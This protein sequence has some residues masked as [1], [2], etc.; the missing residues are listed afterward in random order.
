MSD[1]SKQ[2][3]VAELLARNG[4]QGATSSGGRRRRGARGISVAELTGDLPVIGEGGS[5]SAHAAPEPEVPEPAGFQ[6][7]PFQ[8][9]P[10]EPG[11]SEQVS[12]SPP[13]PE[14]DYSPISGP[15]TRYDPL[16]P[17]PPAGAE[18]GDPYGSATGYGTAEPT[19]Y[20][21]PAPAEPSYAPAEVETPPPGG[22][23]HSAP[24]PEESGGMP[25][26]P[27]LGA[28]RSGRRRK[29]D[30]DENETMVV[31]PPLREPVEFDPS[32]AAPGGSVSDE[33]AARGGRAARRRAA[34]AE[35]E[36]AGP[37]T[38][39]WSP[40]AGGF[41]PGGYR[42]NGL[43]PEVDG[44]FASNGFG[45]NGSAPGHGGSF[46][47]NG[48]GSDGPVPG[49]GGSFA[50]GGFAPEPDGG[51]APNGFAPEQ[52][53]NYAPGGFAPEQGAGEFGPNGF[54]PEGYAPHGFPPKPGG[55]PPGPDSGNG[56]GPESYG[57]DPRG[58]FAPGY[59]P[60]HGR[61]FGP[62]P[63][64][65]GPFAPDA[66][67]GF[68]PEADAEPGTPHGFA[69]DPEPKPLS[70]MPER[71]KEPPRSRTETLRSRAGGALPAWSARR[72]KPGPPSPEDPD[73]ESGGIP[74]AAW[75]LASQDQQ[76]LSGSTVAGDLLRDGVE[77]SERGRK[78]PPA[79]LDD[80]HTD[81]YDPFTADVDEYDDEDDQDEFEAEPRGKLTSLS[82]GLR[83]K[84]LAAGKRSAERE[85]RPDLDEN[86]RQWMILGGQSAG[87][88]IAGMLLFKGFER[89]WEMLPW[90][91]LPLATI[92]ILGLVALVRVLRRTDDIL[93]TGIAVVVGVFVTLGPLA[94][95]L[96]TG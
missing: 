49:S 75:S 77:R 72:H 41:E 53:G 24:G 86:R 73:P 54:A 79:D 30:P 29:Q 48:F 71:P 96:S 50:P 78:R 91:A 17:Y 52:G 1:E 37:S 55:F 82:R 25:A 18:Q 40:A 12:Y 81:A 63:S 32:A 58:G 89:M 65:F 20:S 95:L 84:A 87:A 70:P 16:A 45:P 34:E 47:P 51:F 7:S 56:F 80:G 60:E 44:D 35:E 85:P 6:S 68:G 13:Q 66:G 21:S 93:S 94:F 64:A 67:D 90:V 43:V 74:T 3:S 4:Q 42:P 62:P 22:S 27:P 83:A 19:A 5:H 46:A 8:P 14:S 28:R 23:R 69:P 33:G 10:F 38:A 88:A 57:P 39:A 92:V 9:S 15:I 11:A 31:G 26:L 61:G 76:L 36:E 59:G 2:L